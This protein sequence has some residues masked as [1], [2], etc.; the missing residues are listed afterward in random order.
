MKT[1]ARNELCGK[2]IDLKSGGVISEAVVEINKDIVISANITNDS[3]DKLGLE[4]G[5]EV[6]VLVKSS[7]IILAKGE[8]LSSAR[9]NIKGTIKEIIKGA[10]NSEVLVSVGDKTF[11]AIV[12]NSSV[13]NLELT[14][15]CEVCAIFKASSVILIA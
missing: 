7:S 13:E 10:V 1:S 15:G 2:I 4:I 11:C 6:S 14:V 9:N 3:K 8:L 5:K 12:T